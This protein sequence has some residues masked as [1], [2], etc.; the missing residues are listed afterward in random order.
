[1]DSALEVE[2]LSVDFAGHLALDAVSFTLPPTQLVGLLGPNGAGKSTLFRAI[3]GQVDHSGT[4]RVAGGT[5]SYVPQG[6]H[7]EADFPATAAD[8]ALM[9]R[10]GHRRWWQRLSRGDHAAAAAA[11][12]AVGMGE[13][14][15]CTFGTLSGGQ[16]QRVMLARALAHDKPVILL[17][18]PM[19][20]V[21]SVSREAIT[22]TITRLRDEGRTVLMST[23]D[24]SDAARTCDR[25]I[26]LNRRIIHDGP[27]A[28]TFTPEVIQAAYEGAAVM[29]TRPDGGSFGV[30]DDAH[31]HDHGVAHG[32][33]H[34]PAHE[35]HHE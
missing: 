30:L 20:G 35:E 15:D 31:H 27:P 13:H 17:D 34:A 5:P 12:D 26:F 33:V 19:T 14:A 23:H 24:L 32:H 6:D 16:R 10:Y 25:L 4:V 18:E 7:V 8:V 1:V 3:L 21:D 29:L 11:L 28:T 2:R 22:A 9:G